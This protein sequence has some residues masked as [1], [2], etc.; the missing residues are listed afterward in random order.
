[1]A[2]GS[3]SSS[4]TMMVKLHPSHN[5][6]INQLD[7]ENA[8]AYGLSGDTSKYVNLF[9]VFH[10]VI[11]HKNYL[12]REM[13]KMVSVIMEAFWNRSFMATHSL[14]GQKC[15]SDKSDNTAK[16]ALP[17]EETGAIQSKPWQIL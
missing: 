12:D 13:N 14:S 15:R 5:V 1:M 7:L 11:T 2:I 17:S 6:L 4:S 9:L 16:P 3:Q 10:F 8:V